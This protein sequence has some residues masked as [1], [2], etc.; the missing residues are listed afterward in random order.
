[1]ASD[2]GDADRV[3]AYASEFLFEESRTGC[4]LV[5]FDRVKRF[6]LKLFVY[7]LLLGAV[8]VLVA[9][10]FGFWPSPALVSENAFIYSILSSL[11]LVVLA[12]FLT[13]SSFANRGPLKDIFEIFRDTEVGTFIKR[14]NVFVF[15]LL[16]SCAGVVEEVLFRGILQHHLGLILSSFI[17]GALHAL[18]PAYFVIATLI[19]LYLGWIYQFSD[20]LIVPIVAH[21]V[22]DFA[23]LLL[24]QRKILKFSTGF[25][26][27]EKRPES[28]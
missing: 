24:Y 2:D 10:L 20:Q 1:M 22:Y 3:Q 14:S 6:E 19:S 7:E 9:Y 21:A 27:W 11:P 17:F 23:A 26:D 28:F 25:N 4:S 16:A 5:F 18:T 12:F 13:T 15:V 8:G